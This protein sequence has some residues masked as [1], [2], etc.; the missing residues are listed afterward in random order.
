MAYSQL[1]TDSFSKPS[2]SQDYLFRTWR[3]SHS[4]P[5][6][7][8]GFIMAIVIVVSFAYKRKTVPNVREPEL[9]AE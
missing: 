1:P 4:S 6:S 9:G 8:L 7:Y 3:H 2:N 5:V